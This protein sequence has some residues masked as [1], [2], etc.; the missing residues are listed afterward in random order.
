MKPMMTL[1]NLKTLHDTN[2]EAYQEACKAAFNLVSPFP[3]WKAPIKTVASKTALLAL[4]FEPAVIAH[5]VE[6]F[7]ATACKVTETATD[8][9]FEAAG[10][11]AGPAC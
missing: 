4:G 10:Y 2:T 7:T 6:F 3:H 9:T 1:A 5:A 8:V 11:W